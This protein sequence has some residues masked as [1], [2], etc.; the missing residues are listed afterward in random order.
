MVKYIWKP[1]QAQHYGSAKAY[2]YDI[3]IQ[4]YLVFFIRF[5]KQIGEAFIFDLVRLI[6]FS[7]HNVRDTWKA[8]FIKS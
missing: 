1:K 5:S 3:R 7:L 2:A 6:G 4:I 8:M